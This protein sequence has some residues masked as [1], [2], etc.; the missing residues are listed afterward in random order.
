VYGMTT[1]AH[2]DNIA[3]LEVGEGGNGG[4]VILI[5]DDKGPA[6]RQGYG[7]VHHVSFRVKDHDA[8]EA[9]ATKYKEVGINNSGIVNRF[10]F[11]ALYARVGHILIEISTDGP[12]FMEDEPYETLGEGLSLPP[13]LENKREY[14]ESEV[15]PFNTKRQ[16][17]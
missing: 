5:K 14:I 10:Y 4:Q 2:E 11:E 13:F 17:D 16:H 6:A 8:I 12:G 3:L 9:W 7:E 15:R 1:I